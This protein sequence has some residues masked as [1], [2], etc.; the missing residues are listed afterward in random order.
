MMKTESR[1]QRTEDRWQMT[2]VG[3][4]LKNH[5]SKIISH[6][7]ERGFSLTEVLLAVGTL[8]VGML[9]IA[10]VFPVSI[11]FTTVAS[12]RTIA[13]AAADEAFAKIK[14]Y[15]V[16]LSDPDLSYNAQALYENVSPVVV[17]SSEFAYP[18]TPIKDVRDPNYWWSAICRKVGASDVQVT[19][20]VSRKPGKTTNY[21]MRDPI[22]M[23][24]LITAA[25]PMPVI[26][27]VS[28]LGV[29]T[30]E[31]M[32]TDSMP[33]PADSINEAS[34]IN[35][36]YTIVEHA[37]GHIYRILERYRDDTSTPLDESRII[38]LDRDWQGGGAVWVVPP[39]IG[40]G[41]YP[42]I[43]VYQKVMRF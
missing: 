36:G 16:N 8:A 10:G 38:R 15:G 9:F 21:Y 37:D 6:K 35:D 28:A 33:P 30:D 5:K 41:R 31:R 13:A 43:A 7:S 29:A 1:R 32:I 42:C 20:F 14:L 17:P 3:M 22:S 11:H 4:I 2:A 39:P 19:V 27:S 40:G 24:T 34:F 26:V 12:E 23:P 25:R 18:S